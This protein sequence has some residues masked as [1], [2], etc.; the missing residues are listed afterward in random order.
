[1]IDD[2]IK[3]QVRGEVLT[4][5]ARKELAEA[6]VK[7]FINGELVFGVENDLPHK[8]G[9]ILNIGDYRRCKNQEF[10]WEAE[11]LDG[12]LIKQFEGDVEN[13]LGN[14]D[15]T[16]LKLIR[17]VSNFTWGTDNK[18]KRVIVTLDWA[19]GMFDFQNG[20]VPQEVRAALMLGFKMVEK[21]VAA[22]LILKMR[23]MV[24]G[25]AGV[26]S[27]KVT[28]TGRM[29]LYNRFILGWEVRDTKLA[30]CIE[31]NGYINLHQF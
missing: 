30:V 3:D 2:L 16:Q 17:W 25:E 8:H 9:Q 18:E 12:T 4:Q 14:I 28:P 22:H 11:Y 24:S 13:H 20:L 31:P 23:K 29:W 19:T 15:Q 27:G 21:D 6:G 1:M 26:D 7:T 10:Y 5:A